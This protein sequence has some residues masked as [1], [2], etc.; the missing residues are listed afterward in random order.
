MIRK[1]L[2]WLA[3]P[4]FSLWGYFMAFGLFLYFEDKGFEIF[5]GFGFLVNQL[6]NELLE[7]CYTPKPKNDTQNNLRITDE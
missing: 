3:L 2:C 6:W 5:F 4:L 1:L 7:D